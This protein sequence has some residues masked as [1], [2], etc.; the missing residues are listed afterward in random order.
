MSGD[1][2]W[3]TTS[4]TGLGPYTLASVN[5]AKDF[6]DRWSTGGT[7]IFETYFRNRDAAEWQRAWCH[8]SAANTLVVDR[9]VESSNANNAVSFTAGTIDVTHD[10]S[11]DILAEQ[12]SAANFYT[13]W[14]S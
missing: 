11:L 4:T 14:A 8:L 9:V 6:S 2:I 1:L 13:A 10:K 5:G 7:E 12:Y 3:Q